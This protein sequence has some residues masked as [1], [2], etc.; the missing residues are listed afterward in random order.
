MI[1]RQGL[2]MD[3]DNQGNRVREQMEM[4]SI[5]TSKFYDQAEIREAF[6]VSSKRILEAIRTKRLRGRILGRRCVVLGRHLL[7]WLTDES[8]D[9]VTHK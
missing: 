5:D 2:A 7:E 4:S 8:L 3:R 9:V 1:E 6:G